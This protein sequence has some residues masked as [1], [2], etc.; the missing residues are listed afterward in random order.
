MRTPLAAALTFLALLASA[1]AHGETAA[2]PAA[3]P[4]PVKML[5]LAN[6]LRVFLAPD[7]SARLVSLVV[8]Y[9]AGAGDDPNGRRG[10]AHLV[11]HMVTKRTK[12]IEHPARVLESAGGWRFN[13]ATSLDSTTYFESLP[14]ERLETALWLES[15]RMG[16][17][18]DAVTRASVEEEREVVRNE[19][20]DR[21]VDGMLVTVGE[22][23]SHALFPNWHP[24]S[25]S[26]DGAA[27]LDDLGEQDVRAFLRTWYTPSNATLAIAGRFDCDATVALV[28]HYFEA[29]PSVAAPTRPP[30]PDWNTPS[31]QLVVAA[32]VV[33]DRVVVAWRTP[34][35]GERDDAALDLVAALLSGRGN[36]R[37]ERSLVAK[38]L[39][40][41]TGARQLSQRLASTF[42]VSVEV[43]PG[44]DP[45]VVD[46]A[47]Q[48]TI[49]ELAQNLTAAELDR[50][51]RLL[52]DSAV[53]SLESTWGRAGRLVSLAKAKKDWLRASDWGL[54][55]YDQLNERDV[56]RVISTWLG[57]T[58]R[59]STA[60]FANRA[61]PRRGSLLA[62]D[63]VSP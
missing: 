43:A 60:V 61:A 63:S 27:D 28:K 13:A 53:G 23:V 62:R 45:G 42:Y 46:H 20:R 8:S 49:D 57:R 39:A 29:L 9:A 22:S 51:K 16:Y 6:G 47:I 3:P 48:T 34:A 59:V 4:L 37:L 52:R 12:H 56:R 2:P 7:P 36:V 18:A 10:L 30:L 15:D 24:Y 32:P 31:L 44:A 41:A 54:D 17:A 11:E 55:T 58:H 25:I 1:S 50:A 5:L 33:G 14:P 35:F 21:T 19:D 40:T 26:A 38:Q